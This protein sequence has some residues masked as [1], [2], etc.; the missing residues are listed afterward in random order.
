MHEI[1]YAGHALVICTEE[2]LGVDQ[3][4]PLWMASDTNQIKNI[5]STLWQLI[6][7]SVTVSD[8]SWWTQ[9]VVVFVG[10]RYMYGYRFP[11]DY[12]CQSTVILRTNL[13]SIDRILL[14]TCSIRNTS[15]Q[16]FSLSED[17]LLVSM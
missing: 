17:E 10:K 15:K 6:Y 13:K 11:V 14:Q 8:K 16:A 5:S 2:P 1:A 12:K 9:Q 4:M 7:L 3:S